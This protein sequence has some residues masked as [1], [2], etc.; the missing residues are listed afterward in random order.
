MP[1]WPGPSRG[2]VL[3]ADNLD[4]LAAIP[5]GAVD[6]AYADPPFATGRRAP[7]GLDPDRERGADPAAGSAAARWPT[8]PS[9]TWPGT[10]TCRWTSTSRRSAARLR[11]I[12]RVLAPHGSLYLHVDWR[13]VA[14]R[15][16]AA[17]RGVRAGAVPQR[18]RLGLRLRR[19]GAGPLAAQARHDPVVR[20]G[21]PLAVRPRG[22]RP[23]PVHGARASW[24]PRRRPAASS[25]PTSGG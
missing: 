18:D 21:R 20:E 7:P 10:T 16:A 14:P 4:V 23:D 12:H 13:T 3:E 8:R 9:A 11:E 22:D 24:D 1:S 6:L 25:R 17:G 19:P 5:D 15:A 2:A